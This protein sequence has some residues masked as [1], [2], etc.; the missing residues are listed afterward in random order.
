MIEAVLLGHV[1]L[2][3]DPF[4]AEN[5]PTSQRLKRPPDQPERASPYCEHTLH[6]RTVSRCN[7]IAAQIQRL[8][9]AGGVFGEVATGCKIAWAAWLLCDV[10]D[11]ALQYVATGRCV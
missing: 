2:F 11:L 4:P 7:E 3:S 9:I 5:Q 10:S 6:G 1:P 8:A